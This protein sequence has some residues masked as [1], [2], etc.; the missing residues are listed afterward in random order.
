VVRDLLSGAAY[1]WRGDRN[2]V[3]LDPGTQVPAH[4]FRLER[5]PA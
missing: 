2:Y 3:R 1:T 5:P 4:I